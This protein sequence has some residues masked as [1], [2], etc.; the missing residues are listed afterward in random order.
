MLRLKQLFNIVCFYRISS[1]E[2]GFGSCRWNPRSQ[3]RVSRE[4]KSHRRYSSHTQRKS[5]YNEFYPKS[6][7]L[8]MR[9]KLTNIFYLPYSSL[10]FPIACTAEKGGRP[11]I[12]NRGRVINSVDSPLYKEYRS[13]L[14]V[15]DKFARPLT[16]EFTEFIY[17]KAKVFR[18]FG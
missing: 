9:G 17:R 11:E 1:R 4:F 14:M 13:N 16:L 8:N 15:N 5:L 18:I 2:S 6:F 3:W 12:F 10:F 7:F